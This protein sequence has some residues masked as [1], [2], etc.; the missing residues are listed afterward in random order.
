MY[1]LF[2]V[3]CGGH[4]NLDTGIYTSA[5]PCNPCNPC[6]TTEGAFVP[7]T[8]YV[9][10]FCRDPDFQYGVYGPYSL[11]SAAETPDPARGEW[12]GVP[13]A[14]LSPDGR[15]LFF[16]VPP[17]ASVVGGMRC[18]GLH[19][20]SVD[21]LD[22]L[23]TQVLTTR[24][25]SFGPSP[26]SDQDAARAAAADDGTLAGGFARL[27]WPLD[28]CAVDETIGVPYVDQQLIFCNDRLHL[29]ATY[30]SDPGGSSARLSAVLH[31]SAVERY[32]AEA[33]ARYL[34]HLS[35]G[36]P[37]SNGDDALVE[38]M[39]LRY[40]R[41]NCHPITADSLIAE[42]ASLNDPTPYPL[43]SWDQGHARE[44]MMMLFYSQELGGLAIAGSMEA[45][46]LGDC[47][48]AEGVINKVEFPTFNPPMLEAL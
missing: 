29:F 19:A 23:L 34:R 16:Y 20:A 11:L 1:L 25:P 4:Y 42:G 32:D 8:N 43:G 13:M 46:S 26:L 28:V 7:V 12:I 24:P 2:A 5:D 14:L 30:I 44:P 6:Q 21:E 41:G 27:P 40:E 22:R 33:L 18:A 3:Q 37:F 10:F 17:Q 9:L 39:L 48:L 38:A 36:V 47:F 31:A 45:C 35:T 15:F